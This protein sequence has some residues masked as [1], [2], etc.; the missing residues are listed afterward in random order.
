MDTEGLSRHEIRKTFGETSKLSLT[1]IPELEGL[2]HLNIAQR[3]SIAVTLGDL[4]KEPN[5]GITL[6]RYDDKEATG[7]N[8]EQNIQFTGQGGKD[9]CGKDLCGKDMCGKDL[10]GKGRGQFCTGK[11]TNPTRMCKKNI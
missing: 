10:C 2:L 4:A 6:A 3:R 11:I 1:R 5:S 7:G 8:E 9:L